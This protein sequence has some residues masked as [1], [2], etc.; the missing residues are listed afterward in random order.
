MHL[1][2][3]DN[4]K[5]CRTV[6]API[7]LYDGFFFLLKDLKVDVANFRLLDDSLPFAL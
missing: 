6:K 7:N 4:L 3:E 2:F 1:I 5:T